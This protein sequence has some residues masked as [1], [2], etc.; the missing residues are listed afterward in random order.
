MAVTNYYF[1]IGIL[2]LVAITSLPFK[3]IGRLRDLIQ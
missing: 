1:I 3:S 2:A